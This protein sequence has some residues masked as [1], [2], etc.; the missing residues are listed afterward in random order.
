MCVCVCI[1]TMMYI[2][3]QSRQRACIHTIRTHTAKLTHTPHCTNIYILIQK[4][5]RA[6]IQSHTVYIHNLYLHTCTFRRNL[7]THK[8]N[9]N[10]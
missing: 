6:N 2:C 7:C 1:D 3:I 8:T 5:E 9:Y 10:F 4:G